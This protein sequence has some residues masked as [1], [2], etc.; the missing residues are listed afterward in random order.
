[1][2]LKNSNFRIQN[3]K[4]YFLDHLLYLLDIYFLDQ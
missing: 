2:S 1:M 4:L 3:L